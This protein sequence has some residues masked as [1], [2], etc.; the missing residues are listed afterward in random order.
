MYYVLTCFTNILVHTAQIYCKHQPVCHKMVSGYNKKKPRCFL[1][2]TE[3]K[4]LYKLRRK[5]IMEPGI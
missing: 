2:I 5:I 3:I 4:I 1:L